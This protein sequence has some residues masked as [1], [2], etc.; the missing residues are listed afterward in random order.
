MTKKICIIF[1]II[2]LLLNSSLLSIVSLATE[3]TTNIGSGT[4]GKIS[5]SLSRTQFTNKTQGELVITGILERTSEDSILY[6]NPHITFEFPEEVEKVVINNYKLLYDTELKIHTCIVETNENGNQVIEVQLSGKQT[7]TKIDELTKGTNIVISANVILKQDIQTKDTTIKMTCT[8]G[9]ATPTPLK[10]TVDVPIK[11]VNQNELIPSTPTDEDNQMIVE[12]DGLKLSINPIHGDKIL[13]NG[14]TIFSNEIIKYEIDVTNISQNPIDNFKVIGHI[15]EGMVYVDYLEENFEFWDETYTTVE[16]LIPD[17][18]G[19]YWQDDTYQYNVDE[20]L[21]NVEL[22]IGTI[23]PGETK[24]VS[25][26]VKA[27]I[28]TE[29]N[30]ESNIEFL[31]NDSNIYTFNLRNTLK[32]SD[33]EVRMRQYQSRMEKN[34]FEYNIV[35]KNLSDET[36]SGTINFAIPNNVEVTSVDAIYAGEGTEANYEIKDGKISI[37]V[38]QIE[39]E[40]FR[41][42]TLNL[43]VNITEETTDKIYEIKVSSNFESSNEAVYRANECIAQGGIESLSITQS[44][45]TS[46]ERIQEFGEIIYT[47]EITNTGYTIDELGGYTSFVF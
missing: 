15:P 39:P 42:Y 10:L 40:F 27:K 31:I 8:D 3:A 5:M 17:K 24:T 37:K 23:Q 12:K 26:E 35:I 30:A 36:K 20:N 38:D 7:K 43:K 46:G 41:A 29:T 21:K 44:S 1:I 13:E 16:T 34:N 4:K 11:V 2:I 28:D 47:Y 33:V 25:Y 9:A 14:E 19:V 32:P 45:E 22:N 6:E 18:N